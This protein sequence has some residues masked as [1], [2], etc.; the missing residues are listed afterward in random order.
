MAPLS[1]FAEIASVL[2]VAS[3]LGAVGM[4]LRQPLIVTFIV[5]GLLVGPAG[6]GFV[7]E[8]EQVELL[9]SVGISLLLFVVGLKLDTTM[10]RTVGPVALATGVGQVVFTSVIGYFIALALG[11]APVP[12]LYL[13]VALTFSSTIIIVKLLSDKREID[14]LHGRIAVGFL[15]VQDFAVIIV[16]MML[17]ALGAGV[18]TP[19]S[20]VALVLRGL[21]FLAA[22]ALAARWG[23]P[24]VT[25][26]ISRLPELLVLFG[27]AWAVAVAAA[28]EGLGFSKEVGAFVAGVSLASTPYRDALGARLVTLRDFLLLF[29]FVDLGARLDLSLLG[30][31]LVHSLVF[32][33]FVLI[34][35]PIIVMVIMGVMGYR[36]RTG[37]LCG[38]A[39]AQISEFSLILGTL[40]LSLGH[41]E[42]ET[43]GL[44]TS[45]GLV[46][47][48]LST[49]MIIYSGPLYERLAPLLGLFERKTAYREMSA[50]APAPPADVDVIIF[51]LGRYGG[52][53]VRHLRL[54]N[55]RVVGV[56][57]DPQALSY[58]RGQGLPVFYG[59]AADPELFEHLPLGGATWVVS[60]APEIETSR[61][62][63][64]H[65]KERGYAGKVAVACR[66]AEDAEQLRIEG[67]DLLLRPFADAAE[68]AVDALLSGMDRLSRIASSAVG[69]TEVRLAPGS[70]LAGRTIG[71]VALG[72]R[73]GV[74][75]LA[76]SRSGSMYFN[77]G[78]DFQLF[79]GD[80]VI[81]SGDAEP[82]AAAATELQRVEFPDRSEEESDFSLEEVP[83]EA[84]SWHGQTIAD[85]EVRNRF[86]VTVVALRAGD[87]MS[88]PNPSHP[89]Q[90]GDCLI[91]AG[92]RRSIERLREAAVAAGSRAG[93]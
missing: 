11:F 18:A 13:A 35:N 24:W 59:D 7:T 52:S 39:V 27:I 83:V 86:G 21:A 25:T 56:D 91:V 80:R 3:A 77:P 57:F 20:A 90:R 6:F 71:Q 46:T 66:T 48:G 72:E 41:I 15:I 79:P 93:L 64:R 82:L 65:L 84:H 2:L 36:K 81:L 4:W 45:V 70:P 32:S 23:L 78:A 49:Y 10:I 5:V 26:Q 16:M 8:H 75:A 31:T 44:I 87:R 34:G 69:L 88:A 73:W 63:L 54:R 92:S 33:L 61:V 40:G 60:T 9:A 74:T 30:A 76:V 17:T 68:Q 28:S 58:W 50:D 1:A 47:I 22:M 29:F 55:K 42:A 67:A 12:A 37:F 19:L 53:I 62:L 43:M 85:L 14:A 89:L 51:G 38:L